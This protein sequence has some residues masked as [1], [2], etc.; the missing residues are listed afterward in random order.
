[1]IFETDRLYLRQYEEEDFDALHGIFSDPD[2]MSY[3]PA[4]F[5]AKQTRGWMARNR[6]RYERDGCGLWAVCLKENDRVIGDSGLIYQNINGLLDVEIGYHL[7]KRCWGQ[8]FAAEAALGCK[9]HAFEVLKLDRVVSIIH[10][11]NRRSIRVAER[12][13]MKLDREEI[14]F[15][16]KHL[17]YAVRNGVC[18]Q[19]T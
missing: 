9:C 15:G 11:D 4:A 6:E 19:Q 3:Y 14:V 12:V 2:T 16:R 10:P 5:S 17:I 7:D 13:G 18:G 8:G 1:M